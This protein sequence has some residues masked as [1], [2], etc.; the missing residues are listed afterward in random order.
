MIRIKRAHI[1]VNIVQK[2]CRYWQH[3][4]YQQPIIGKHAMQQSTTSTPIAILEGMDGLELCMEDCSLHH[5]GHI[6]ARSKRNNVFQ[7][8]LDP[9][10]MGRHE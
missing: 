5:T 2:T 4:M 6:V 8:F 7:T 10:C 1:T 9:I 3:C